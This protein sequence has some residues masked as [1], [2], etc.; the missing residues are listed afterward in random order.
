MG[1]DWCLNRAIS[2]QLILKMI[3]KATTKIKEMGSFE[4]M[5]GLITA[6]T[7]FI[8]CYHVSLCGSEGM[9]LIL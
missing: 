1:Q 2:T 5:A 8:L 6:T 9:L 3:E 4:F 7:Y